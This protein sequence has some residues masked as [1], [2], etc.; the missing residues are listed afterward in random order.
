[1]T[2]SPATGGHSAAGTRFEDA[3]RAF[4]RGGWRRRR[5]AQPVEAAALAGADIKD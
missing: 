2:K 4:N 1:M 5:A 3:T